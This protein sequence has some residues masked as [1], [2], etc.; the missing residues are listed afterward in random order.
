MLKGIFMATLDLDRRETTVTTVMDLNQE[1]GVEMEGVYLFRF[2]WK[3]EFFSYFMRLREVQISYFL[4]VLRST[5]LH[6]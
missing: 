3:S 1:K 5:Q 2:G 6:F 4:A